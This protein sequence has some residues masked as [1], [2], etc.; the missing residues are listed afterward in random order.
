M[1]SGKA[2]VTGLGAICAAGTS[3]SEIMRALYAGE[4]RPAP[5]QN[6]RVDL[7]NIY[8]VFEVRDPLEGLYRMRLEIEPTT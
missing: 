3:L 5:P 6:I 8:P 7:A 4:R 1:K 2:V